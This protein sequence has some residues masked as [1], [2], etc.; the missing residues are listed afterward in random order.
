MASAA[1]ILCALL[2][3][4]FVRAVVQRK[5]D[6]IYRIPTVGGSS[7]PLLSYRTAFNFLLHAKHLIQEGYSK[8]PIFK[9][10]MFNQWIV[11]V[12]GAELNEELR[13]IPDE[14]MSF[15]EA[16][17]EL[18][19][20]KYT[21]APER[22]ESH[23]TAIRNQLTRNISLVLPD[24]IDEITTTLKELV[25]A[26][27]DGKSPWNKWVAV[28]AL[29]SV[30]S[31]VMRTTNRIFVGLPLCRD[32]EY[33]EIVTTYLDGVMKGCAILFLLPGFLK[34]FVGPILPWVKRS[35]RRLYP[36]LAPTVKERIRQLEEH[37]KTSEDLTMWTLEEMADFK[38]RDPIE[39]LTQCTLSSNAVALH[40][41]SLTMAHALYDLAA[42][43][44][45]IKPLRE[46]IESAIKQE[47]WTKAAMG[48]MW[49][50]DSFLKESS[51]V[52]G[53]TVFSLM[54]KAVRDLTLSNGTSIPAGC[55]VTATTTSTHMDGELYDRP[56]AFEPFRFSD[57]RAQE[58]EKTKNHFVT[59]SSGF[60]LF[61]HG[62]HA[63]PGR[64]FAASQLKLIL[65]I[66]VLSYDIKFADGKRPENELMATTIFPSRSAKM[67]FRLR[68]DAPVAL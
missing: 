48:K 47:G 39:I 24:M 11:V 59:T 42:H 64:F 61:G 20:A 37:K 9:V 49:K 53:V 33:I 14:D 36:V 30:R 5:T 29:E 21:I 16:A 31:I 66:T 10:A 44:E 35:I 62:K 55:F 15:F 34:P 17:E 4:A 50:V 40:T 8:Y 43:P 12:S 65:I 25:P 57:K 2:L 60:L 68:Q 63:C 41:T 1:A 18:V 58:N 32:P 38:Q 45:Y 3:I 56:E 27:G 19:Q 13:R 67:M 54:R 6:P 46:E 7:A 52:H 51:R 23:L 26:K 28:P 22:H